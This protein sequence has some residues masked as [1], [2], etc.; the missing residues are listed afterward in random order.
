VS[1]VDQRRAAGSAEFDAEMQ[2]LSRKADQADEA[3]SR[4]VV[5]CRLERTTAVAGGAVGGRDWFVFAFAGV[6]TT[7][8]SDACTEAGTFFA[9]VDQVK[10]GVCV[11]EDRARMSWV[12]PGTRRDIRRKYR[13]DWDG[14]DRVCPQ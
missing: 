4:F 1:E 7:R 12:Y 2:I 9:L 6:T 8:W 10:A 13:L 11:A 5:G 3:W 14:W